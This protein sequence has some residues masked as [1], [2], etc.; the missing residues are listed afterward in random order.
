[1]DEMEL[2]KMAV[3]SGI[4][5]ITTI[6]QEIEM[7]KRREILACHDYNIWQGS[8]GKWFTYIYDETKPKNRKLVKRN[9]QE[10]IEQFVMDYLIENNKV[11]IIKK[12]TLR[13]LF[14]EWIKY[15]ENHTESTSYIKRI[16]ADWKKHYEDDPISD[17][18]IDT[19]TKVYLD[20]WAHNKIKK[21]NLKKKQ[22]YNMSVIIRQCLDYAVEVGYIEHN[23]FSDFKVNAKMFQKQKKPKSETQVYQEEEAEKLLSDMIRRYQANKNNLGALMVVLAFET[24]MRIGEL[25]ALKWDDVSSDGLHLHIQRQEV[26]DYYWVDDYTM[27]FAGYKVVE[28]TKTE[29]GD[30]EI[31]L[32]ENARAILEIVKERTKNHANPDGFIFCQSNG[33]NVNHYSVQ[34]AIKRGCENVDIMVKSAHKIRKTY[35]STLI[36][37]GLNIDEIRRAVGHKDERTTYACY[38]FN[39]LGVSE[40]EKLIEQSLNKANKMVINI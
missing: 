12:H 21:N 15:K 7:K 26:R 25:C 40:T 29:E 13:N 16:S 37:S 31:Y 27:S 8:N 24:G 39:R 33:K 19:F 23:F 10:D 28:Y 5:D 3:E 32:T 34:A 1:M 18:P 14:P 35:I 9:T 30:R 11:Q 22:Y 4:V 6:Q 38:C 36:D 2:L 17:V 20:Q